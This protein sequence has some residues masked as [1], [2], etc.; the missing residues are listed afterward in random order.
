MNEKHIYHANVR[1]KRVRCS[2]KQ[3]SI[4]NP[5]KRFSIEIKKHRSFERCL[6]Y[7][8]TSSMT[9]ISAASPRRGPMRVMRV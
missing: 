2:V 6:S 1:A 3:N 9:A 7:Y 5:A 4:E 8:Q